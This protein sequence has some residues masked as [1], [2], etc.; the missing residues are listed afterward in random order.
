MIEFFW[1]THML[2]ELFEQ[3]YALTYIF[4]ILT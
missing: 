1:T 3:I 2:F 4:I